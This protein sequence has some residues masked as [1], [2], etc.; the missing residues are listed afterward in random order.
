MLVIVSGDYGELGGAMYFLRGLGLAEPPTVL[1]PQSLAHAVGPSGQMH[2]HAYVSLA[3]IEGHLA[4]VRPQAVMLFSGYLLAIGPRFSLFNAL[5]LLRTLRRAGVTVLTS[6]PF[7]G[8][9]HGP[10]ALD[11]SCVL[12]TG[13]TAFGRKL[14]SWH[15]A[16]RL[17]LLKRQLRSCWHIYPSPIE[18]L[19]HGAHLAR[20]LSYFNAPEAVGSGRS[21]QAQAQPS[22][23]FVLSQIDGLMQ[24]RSTDFAQQ[25]AQRLE[26]TVR[27]GRVAV[28]VA[29]GFVL[30]AVRQRV[31][32]LAGVVLVANE[33]FHDFMQRLMEAEYAFFWNYYSFSVIHRIIAGRPVFFFD[34]GHMV[35][36]LPA[37]HDAGITLFYGGW[38]PPLVAI[39]SPLAEAV[40]E[41][42]AADS[43]LR[44]EG[45]VDGLHRC[46]SPGSVLAAA[47]SGERS[48]Q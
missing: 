15:L 24:S 14:R 31:G 35:H 30:E 1:L 47:M 33:G 19:H 28:L 36:I 5:S 7:I 40:L 32:S 12:G 26:D 2:V 13:G 21:A 18:R 23:L 4:A 43:R 37:L 44:F 8:L 42:R 10:A 11:F 22:W 39:G 45:I 9:I 25:L 20:S 38:R 3:D 48:G 16:L 41:E 29:P 17:A 46:E 27:L 6:D 34:E